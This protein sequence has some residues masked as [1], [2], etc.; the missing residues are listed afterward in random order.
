MPKILIITTVHNPGDARIRYRQI[1]TLLQHGWNVTYAAPF[2]GYG[3][4]PRTQVAPG[5]GVIDLPRAH[6]KRRVKAMGAVRKLLRNRA[7]E[8]DL[9]LLHDPELLIPLS[10]TRTRTR[11]AV[12]DVHEDAAAAIGAK[13]WI[14]R[15]LHAPIYACV[16]GFERWA[17]RR[18]P[19]LLAEYEYQERFRQVHPVVPNAVQVPAK[20]PEAGAHKVVYL[21]ALTIERGA[22]EV[23]ELGRLLSERYAGEVRL[24]VIGPAH[25]HAHQ[26]IA[27][28]H[29]EGILAWH[30]FV[31]SNQALKMLDG[32]LAGLSLLH[33]MPNYRHSMPTKILEYMAHAVPVISTPLPVAAELVREANSG[34]IVPFGDVGAAL[35]FIAE[36]RTEPTL[37]QEYGERGYT[38]AQEKYDWATLGE[39]FHHVLLGLIK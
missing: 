24:D 18:L 34:R 30:G 37:V 11:N 20:Q 10:L 38:A 21:G 28:A 17:E 1:E 31:P 29:D 5:L 19:L 14:P 3:L 39:Q 12:L 4:E 26:V 8:F 25:G 6:G 23:A 9:V 22:R 13:Q 35:E 27:K 15:I 16:R 36:L 32:A 33:D 7:D 2:R